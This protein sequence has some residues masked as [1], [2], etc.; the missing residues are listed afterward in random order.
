MLGLRQGYKDKSCL[1]NQEY[2]GTPDALP[3]IIFALQD[4]VPHCNTMPAFLLRGGAGLNKMTN[5]NGK[6]T[7]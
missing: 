1:D 4:V 3:C 6:I 2:S 5:V 7:F